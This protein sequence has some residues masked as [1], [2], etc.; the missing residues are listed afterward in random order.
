MLKPQ[1]SPV[2]F[3]D[4]PE[5][6]GGGILKYPR[7]PHLEMIYASA[8]FVSPKGE[9]SMIYGDVGV[10]CPTCYEIYSDDILFEDAERYFSE[11]E[12]LKRVNE[13]LSV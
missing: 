4:Q 7:K 6:I 1:P 10:R 13:L 8:V 9:I 12:M 11:Q 5:E 3:I 2:G